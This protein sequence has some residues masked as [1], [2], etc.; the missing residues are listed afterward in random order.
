MAIIPFALYDAFTD[1]V[2][3]GSQAG[4]VLNAA[5]LSKQ[6]RQK[7]ANEIGLPATGFITACDETAIHA[8]FHST[9]TEYPMCGHGTICLIG[10]VKEI[11]AAKST[12]KLAVSFDIEGMNVLNS[13]INMISLYQALGVR[14]GINGM[15]IF[16]GNNVVDNP[17]LL[18]HITYLAE[19][20]GPDHVGLGFDYSPGVDVDISEIL[21]S[22]PGYWPV[23]PGYDTTNIKHAGPSQLAD[24]SHQLRQQGFNDD[25]LRGILGENFKRVAMA[26]WG[27]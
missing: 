19:L 16:L 5:G 7:I 15:G 9:V 1:T 25:E 14:I 21:K 27:G 11:E 2:F 17:T 3:E 24:L 6:T 12:D 13:D 18:R 8:H 22:R 26:C 23:G 20:V 4:V 10:S